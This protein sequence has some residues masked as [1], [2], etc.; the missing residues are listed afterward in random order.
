MDLATEKGELS[1]ELEV[2]TNVVGS[3]VGLKK[4]ERKRKRP[5]AKKL[6]TSCLTEIY[7]GGGLDMNE[8]L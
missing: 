3:M 4:A 1:N 2:Q 8:K 5:K 7:T 6:K